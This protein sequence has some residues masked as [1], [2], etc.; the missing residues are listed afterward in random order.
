MIGRVLIA[1][2]D[3]EIRDVVADVV[4]E[5]GF[6]VYEAVD[7]DSALAMIASIEPPCLVLLDLMM[8]QGTGWA[9]LEAL[10]ATHQLTSF[11]VVII[12]ATSGELPSGVPVLRK[13]F[14]VA[15][16]RSIIQAHCAHDA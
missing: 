13:P 10:Q 11:P 6:E 3:D 9:V 14:S 1:E 4:R 2:D 8:P 7:G 16:L 5:E 12:T 15:Q